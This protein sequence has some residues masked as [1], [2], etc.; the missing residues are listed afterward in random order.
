MYC[1]LLTIWASQLALVVKK[2]PT[3]AGDVGDA[4]LIQEDPLEEGEVTHSS[5]LDRKIPWVEEPGRNPM[6]VRQP[7]PV[8]LP[9]KSHGWR[10]QSI[11]SQKESDTNE[12]T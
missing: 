5:I 8:F 2:L 4:G 1:F 11:E 7:T 6:G 10:L 3:N 9:G 12:V